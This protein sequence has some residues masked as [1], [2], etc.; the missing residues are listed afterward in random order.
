MAESFV[1]DPSIGLSWGDS[2]ALVSVEIF[3]SKDGCEW[4]CNYF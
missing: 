4:P 2:Q 3:Y 1:P